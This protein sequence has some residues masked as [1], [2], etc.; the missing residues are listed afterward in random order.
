MR[1]PWGSNSLF[2]LEGDVHTH[3]LISN[4]N[5]QEATTTVNTDEYKQTPNNEVQ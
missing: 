3:K 2:T 1:G 5:A 4:N